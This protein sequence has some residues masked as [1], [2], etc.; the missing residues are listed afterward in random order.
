MSDRNTTLRI[1]GVFGAA[2]L[3]LALAAPVAAQSITSNNVDRMVA[4]ASTPAD[5]EALATY[6]AT[7]AHAAEIAASRY[8]AK[9]VADRRKRPAGK[10]CR[11]GRCERLIA[12]F[13][14][15]K[16]AYLA[17][18]AEQERLANRAVQ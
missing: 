13:E 12:Q 15:E 8:K 2:L 11:A 1:G 5:H 14:R 6:F 17:R 18:A 7:R 4:A 3:A 10:E 9:Q 16:A